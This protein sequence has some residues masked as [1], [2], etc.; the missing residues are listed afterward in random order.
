MLRKHPKP[1]CRLCQTLTGTLGPHFGATSRHPPA[2]TVTC[3]GRQ[4]DLHCRSARLDHGR[5]IFSHHM[6]IP[7]ADTEHYLLPPPPPF[8]LSLKSS[9]WALQRPCTKPIFPEEDAVGDF[10]PLGARL[11]PRQSRRTP[12]DRKVFA[13]LLEGAKQCASACKTALP[14][15]APAPQSADVEV[16]LIPWPPR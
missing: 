6:C 2:L 10:F 4:V 5:A 3:C 13:G 8:S 16:S 9:R 14:A 1:R 15:S 7:G 11:W 12:A